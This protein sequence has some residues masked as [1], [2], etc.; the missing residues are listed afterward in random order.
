MSEHPIPGLS[1]D[2]EKIKLL[3]KALDAVELMTSDASASVCDQRSN[4]SRHYLARLVEKEPA[5]DLTVHVSV[6]AAAL[7]FGLNEIAGAIRDHGRRRSG[8]RR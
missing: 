1:L 5:L 7:I 6:I 4:E 2:P 8:S 3:H